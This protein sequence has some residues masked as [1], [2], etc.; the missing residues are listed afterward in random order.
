MEA[1]DDVPEESCI[2]AIL[3]DREATHEDIVRVLDH[4]FRHDFVPLAR[5]VSRMKREQDDMKQMLA[6]WHG[7]FRGVVFMGAAISGVLSAAG[8]IIGIYI[9]FH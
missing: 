4:F 7:Q 6:E 3:G 1:E 5:R 8:A 2:K 9:A